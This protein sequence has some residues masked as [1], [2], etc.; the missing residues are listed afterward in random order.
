MAETGQEQPEPRAGQWGLV[1][2]AW[3]AVGVPLAWGIITTLKK[4]APL[5][6]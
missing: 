1:A 5:F 4:A 6:K 2:A 3:V